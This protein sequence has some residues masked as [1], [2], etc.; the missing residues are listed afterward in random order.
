M[1]VWTVIK[2]AYTQWNADNAP[3]L[4]AALAYYTIFSLAPLLV[5]VIGV[6]GLV[7]GKDAARG[8]VTGQV[9]HLV[10]QQGGEAVQ[11]MVANAGE[12]G[13]GTLGTIVGVVMLFL[14]A[15]GLFGQLQAAL[16][17]VWGVR[18]KP[19]GGIWGMLRERFLSLSMVLGVAF[20][21][22]VSL[23]VSSTLAAV[24]GVLGDWQTGI[25]GQVVTTAIDLVVITLLFALIFRYLPDAEVSWKDVWFGAVVTA[26]LFTVGKLLIGLYLGQAAVGSAYGAAGSLAAL[27][28]WI[29]YAAQI[30]LFGAELTQAYAKEHGSRIAPK[31]HAEAVNPDAPAADRPTADRKATQ[32]A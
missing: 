32:P 29:Y 2:S 25:V 28:V 13:H 18:P 9:S 8:Q 4:G 12:P 10:G 27:L 26:V 19:G 24:G 1:K 3:R 20:L 17:T 14:G 7:F 21:L 30:F 6:A 22:I 15:A 23:V 11:T 31:A 5:I 16:N